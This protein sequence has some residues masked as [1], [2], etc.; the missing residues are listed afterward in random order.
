MRII[1]LAGSF[2]VRTVIVKHL[3]QSHRHTTRQ[4]GLLAIRW[5]LA[6]K[7]CALSPLGFDKRSHRNGCWCGVRRILFQNFLR[8]GHGSSIRS[9]PLLHRLR[10]S[11]NIHL[12]LFR[13]S[14]Y[15]RI[16]ITCTHHG[17]T[18]SICIESINISTIH[19]STC[20]SVSRSGG[21]IFSCHHF[22]SR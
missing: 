4:S 3:R 14:G 12:S 22:H 15:S 13:I 9:Q 17:K 18:A 21:S 7:R 16:S 2:M 11:S 1:Q 10:H 8:I 19:G 6:I 20:C 5:T